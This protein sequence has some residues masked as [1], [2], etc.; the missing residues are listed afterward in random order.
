MPALQH[1]GRVHTESADICRWLD[2]ALEGPPLS[3]LSPADRQQ[4][5]ALLRGPCSRAISAGLDLLAGRGR[6]W[7]IGS[8][9]SASQRAAMDAALAELAAAIAATG[10]PF[11]LGPAPTLADINCYPFIKRYS[12][13]APLTGYDVAAAG[14][15][16]V[17]RWLAAMDGRPSAATTAADPALLLQAF[18]TH[19]S[20]DFFDYET[21]SV[22]ELHPHNRHLLP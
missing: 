12:V 16:A 6:S 9:Q 14:G 5:D 11:L 15:G 18:K 19:Q 13:A 17:G 1:G 4:M 2:G 21:Y 10:G 22:F 3:P 20:L 7:G 8:G